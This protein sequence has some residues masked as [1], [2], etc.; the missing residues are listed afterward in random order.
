MR[1]YK[2]TP[3][4]YYKK[5]DLTIML[6]TV[7]DILNFYNINKNKSIWD[8][9]Y[10]YPDKNRQFFGW[11]FRIEELDE[12]INHDFLMDSKILDHKVTNND[13]KIYLDGRHNNESN[14]I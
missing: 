7:K 2:H 10:I 4:K 12:L 9:I 13:L 8:Y 6:K 14:S 3:L 1:G 5:G 11:E